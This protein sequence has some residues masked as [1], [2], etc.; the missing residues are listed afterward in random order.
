MLNASLASG[1]LLPE[2]SATLA[3]APPSASQASLLGENELF[4]YNK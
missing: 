1:F 4:V 2:P 3:W